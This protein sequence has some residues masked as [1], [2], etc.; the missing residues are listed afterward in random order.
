MEN[1]TLL[2]QL[3]VNGG[4][5]A[6][7]AP[8]PPRGHFGAAE[9][10]AA[11]RIL[12]AAIAA[13]GAPGYGGPEEEIFCKEFAAMMGGG[14]ADAVSS[15]TDA[16]FVALRALELPPFSEVVVG[17]ITDPGG[18]MPVVMA[19][20]IPVIADCEPGSFNVSLACIKACVTERT[21]A[22]IVPHI[23]GEPADI[24]AIVDF[25]HSRDIKVVEDCAQAHGT[26]LGGRR[27]GTF[28]DTAAYSMMFG[29]H[30]CMGGQG[31]VVFT[32]SEELYWKIRQHSDR[33]KPFGL[34]A[35]STNCI[36]TLNFNADEL[37]CAVGREQIKKTDAIAAGRRRV[38]QIIRRELADLSGLRFPVIRAGGECSYW[39]LRMAVDTDAL[40]CDKR[41]FAAALEAEAPG[42]IR[43]LADYPATPWQY[44]WF[45]AHRAFGNGY[46]WTAPEYKGDAEKRYTLADLPKTAAVLAS[47]VCLYPYESW[48]DAVAVQYADAIR[49]VYTAFGK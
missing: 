34:P 16:V 8:L 11:D 45:T 10:A 23:A 2:S 12:D 14:Y 32:R 15:G 29:K 5:T 36:A 49:K 13:G 33:G 19:N 44:D 27:V 38:V 7:T 6:L 1:A 41:T 28:G 42:G 31:G 20:C 39:F 22:I 25:A 9:K 4:P 37:G 46:P 47:T 24:E 30:T 3:A 21:S 18:L 40:T 35:G 17:P 43:L 26:K 48:S